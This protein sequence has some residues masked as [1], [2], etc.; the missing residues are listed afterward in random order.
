[1]YVCWCVCVHLSVCIYVCVHVYVCGSMGACV[2]ECKLIDQD[3]NNV[4]DVTE[5]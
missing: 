4:K 2:G 3:T 1:M 5:C